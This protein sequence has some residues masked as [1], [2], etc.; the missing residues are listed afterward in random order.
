M[1]TYELEIEIRG[2]SPIVIEVD[3]LS[4]REYQRIAADELEGTYVIKDVK[5]KE[6]TPAPFALAALPRGLRYCL[7]ARLL[8]LWSSHF[9]AV[10]EY[11]VRVDGLPHELRWFARS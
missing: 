9:L 5:R 2:A 4:L 8:V 11:R 6:S 10:S 3:E 7:R 1:S